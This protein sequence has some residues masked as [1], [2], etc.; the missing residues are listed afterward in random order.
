MINKKGGHM[1]KCEYNFKYGVSLTVAEHHQTCIASKSGVT[2]L[3]AE[4][5]DKG[6][7]IKTIAS[8]REKKKLSYTLPLE[9]KEK[10]ERIIAS[11]ATGVKKG[12]TTSALLMNY[13]FQSELDK[14]FFS[15]PI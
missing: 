4:L 8:R 6:L 2:R 1:A 14:L 5:H 12:L 7:A 15:R 11:R 3:M 13:G 9:F 10:I